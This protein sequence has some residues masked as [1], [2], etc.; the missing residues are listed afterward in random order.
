M[1]HVRAD[2]HFDKV[3][4]VVCTGA[5]R[6]DL[7]IPALEAQLGR[8]EAL[9][10]QR[11]TQ[12]GQGRECEQLPHIALLTLVVYNGPRSCGGRWCITASY[13][14]YFNGIIAPNARPSVLVGPMPRAVLLPLCR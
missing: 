4:G 9:R 8:P 1:L 13:S 12:G 3:D 6:L 11:R 2:R 7:D 14:G 5:G 10:C